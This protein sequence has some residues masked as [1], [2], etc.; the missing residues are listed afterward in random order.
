[1]GIKVRSNQNKNNNFNKQG[2]TIRKFKF[3]FSR[4]ENQ[5]SETVYIN[6]I[7]IHTICK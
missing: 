7:Y 4:M 2:V 3:F 6:R 5:D 1:M